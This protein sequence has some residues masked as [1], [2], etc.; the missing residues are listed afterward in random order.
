ML[1]AGNSDSANSIAVYSLYTLI[2]GVALQ[3]GKAFQGEKIDPRNRDNR[4]A[5]SS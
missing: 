2:V 5:D 1:G 4:S 3:T